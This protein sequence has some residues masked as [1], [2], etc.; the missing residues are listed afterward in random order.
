MSL[1]I[2]YASSW[3][4]TGESNCMK[5][6]L[7]VLIHNS[8][9]KNVVR[10]FFFFFFFFRARQLMPQMYLS[11][12]LIVQGWK[13]TSGEVSFF[14]MPY[15]CKNPSWFWTGNKNTMWASKFT[16]FVF[17]HLQCHWPSRLTFHTHKQFCVPD[18]ANGYTWVH[19]NICGYCFPF[20]PPPLDVCFK[21]PE[22]SCCIV[23]MTSQHG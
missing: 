13:F 11:L 3:W 22:L 1:F 14:D 21:I 6:F 2:T 23:I 19:W 8:A 10:S 9:N 18:S 15:I 17:H 20:V 7:K 5:Y 16:C 12:W 4:W